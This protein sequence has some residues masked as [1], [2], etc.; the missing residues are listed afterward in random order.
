[1]KN[2]KLIAFL[3]LQLTLV[4][5][6][7]GQTEYHPI[8]NNG[9][10]EVN[11]PSTPASQ[12]KNTPTA[13]VDVYNGF[14]DWDVPGTQQ[15]AETTDYQYPVDLE[16]MQDEMLL[17]STPPA[18]IVEQLNLLKS[19]MDQ[20]RAANEELRLENKIIRESLGNCCSNSALNLTAKDAYLLQ[21]SPN[22]YNESTEIKYF[23][24]EGL[25]RVEL[26]I[27]NVKGELVKSITINDSG[28]GSVKMTPSANMESGGVFIY[29]LSIAG[30]VIDSKIMIQNN[31]E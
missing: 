11:T 23:I 4:Q 24:P 29:T 12:T 14:S 21:N 30:Q 1:M 2:I 13:P 26:Q 20:L 18:E 22:P 31:Q 19:E 27:S 25:D 15:A 3:F 5:F 9:R 16:I 6:T 7:F 28:Y 8:D 17:N 10:T